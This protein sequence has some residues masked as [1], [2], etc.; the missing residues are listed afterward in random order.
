MY[1]ILIVEDD[2]VIAERLREHLARWG[3]D[4]VVA[5]DFMDVTGCFVRTAPHL[6]LMDIGLPFFNGYH[7]CAEI[8]KISQVPVVFLSSATDNMNIVMAVQTGGDDFIPKPFDLDVAS[9]KIQAM[10]RR[11]YAFSQA[12]PLLEHRGA[13]LN[14]AD[15]TL[16]WREE[17]I[18]LSRNEF[19]ILEVLMENRGAVVSRETLMQKLW[20]GDCFVD[21]NTLNVNVARLRKRLEDAG[22]EGY[23]Q[24]R[25]GLGYGLGDA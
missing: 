25:K 9:A 6:V 24:T 16:T 17:R 2:R 7:W 5:Q 22:L 10:L 21:D 8:R 19:R 12:L 15:A 20:E 4:P 1:R 3:Y 18:P 13:V 23:I 11:T 14:L